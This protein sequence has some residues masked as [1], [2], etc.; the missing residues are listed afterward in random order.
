V[1]WACAGLQSSKPCLN[2]AWSYVAVLELAGTSNCVKRQV[3]A[4]NIEFIDA[5]TSV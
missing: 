3:V 4:G 5:A 2:K 1:R